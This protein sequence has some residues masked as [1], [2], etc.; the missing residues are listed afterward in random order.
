MKAGVPE[1]I[2]AAG[3]GI[4]AITSEPQTLAREAEQ[5]W[6]LDFP[7]VGDPHHEIADACRERGWL[8]LFVNPK[9]RLLADATGFAAHPKGYFQPGLLAITRTGRVLYRW[10][11]RPTRKN[12]GGATSRPLAEDVWRQIEAAI[13]RGD[14]AGDAAPDE[15]ERLDD[16]DCTDAEERNYDECEGEGP[17]AFRLGALQ[18]GQA[19]D[20]CGHDGQQTDSGSEGAELPPLHHFQKQGD[21]TERKG[22]DVGKAHRQSDSRQQPGDPDP[23]RPLALALAPVQPDSHQRTEKWCCGQDVPGVPGADGNEERVDDRHVNHE[24]AGVMGGL[25]GLSG[26]KR[27]RDR[28]RI[29]EH[30]GKRAE[31]G[32]LRVPDCVD[33]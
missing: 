18:E 10:R 28:K 24:N 30:K 19:S 8:Q 1:K 31:Q 26:A 17:I 7:A 14:S 12:A 15:P 22:V 3:G 16:S 4:F 32:G 25:P 23:V 5:T 21:C 11:G 2:K 29:G 27:A 9:A 33:P 20:Q 13:A 6:E